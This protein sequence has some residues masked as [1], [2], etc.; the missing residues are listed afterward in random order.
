MFEIVLGYAWDKQNKTNL[1]EFFALI[2][3]RLI[4]ISVQSCQ[5]K[6]IIHQSVIFINMLLTILFTVL[7]SKAIPPTKRVLVK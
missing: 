7:S 1:L 2:K 5:N 4:D 6:S 3:Q